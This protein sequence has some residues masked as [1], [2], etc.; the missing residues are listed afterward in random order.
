MYKLTFSK[1]LFEELNNDV[2]QT[3]FLVAFFPLNGNSD[4]RNF[5]HGR[6]TVNWLLMD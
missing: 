5:D 1:T 6:S 2:Y 4:N 3:H